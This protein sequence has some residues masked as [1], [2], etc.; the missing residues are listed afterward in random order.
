MASANRP[1]P[2]RSRRPAWTLPENFR[3]SSIDTDSAC[4]FLAFENVAAH[5]WLASCP[6]HRA[7]GLPIPSHAH[8]SHTIAYPQSMYAGVTFA[9]ASPWWLL[10][11]TKDERGVHCEHPL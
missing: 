2:G 9:D 7:P 11:Q 1:D 4:Y 5:S 10:R 8:F 6:G 3:E